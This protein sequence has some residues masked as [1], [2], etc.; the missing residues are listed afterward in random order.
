VRLHRFKTGIVIRTDDAIRLD[1]DVE[2]RSLAHRAGIDR[3]N[4]APR[5]VERTCSG[6]VQRRWAFTHLL[7]PCTS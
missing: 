2:D 6:I 7:E 3:R 1:M 4:R 5:L